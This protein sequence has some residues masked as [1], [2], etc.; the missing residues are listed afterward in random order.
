M[1]LFFSFLITIAACNAQAQTKIT[2][3]YDANWI[4]TSKEKAAFYAD[5]IKDGTAYSCTSYWIN[6]KTVRGISVFPDTVMQNP[7]GKQILYFKNG[8][9]ADS[10]FTEDKKTIYLFHYYPGGQLAM[11]LYVPSNSSEAVV[12]GFDEDG[13]RIKHYIFQKDAE[14]KGGTKAWQ[15]YIVKNAARDLSVKGDSAITAKVQVQFIIDENGDVIAAKIFKSSGYRNVDN[16]ALRVISDSPK[17]NSAILFNQP[18][19]AYRIQP[20]EYPLQPEK[21]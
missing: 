15:S 1:K 16:D 5:F 6:T 8:R 13:K 2:R 17:W 21:K 3:Y 12:E 9:I 7:I 4:E 19:N 10:S 18:V 14:F 11:H 20:F